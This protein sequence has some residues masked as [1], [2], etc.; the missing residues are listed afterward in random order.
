MSTWSGLSQLVLTVLDAH[1]GGPVAVVERLCHRREV[2]RAQPDR[3][4]HG[5]TVD[6]VTLCK[7]RTVEFM[8]LRIA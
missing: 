2:A 1:H 5:V 6:V 3:R 7:C 4:R 8:L